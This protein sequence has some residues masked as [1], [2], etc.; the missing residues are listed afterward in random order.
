MPK[1][2]LTAVTPHG[3]FTRQTA[4]QYTH[5]V[6]REC[7]EARGA[8][9]RLANRIQQAQAEGWSPIAIAKNLACGVD[10][11]WAKDNGYAVTWHGS[12]GAARKAA[13]GKYLYDWSARVLG[14]YEVR[15]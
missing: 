10:A 2:I 3:T 4:T 1:P 6:V 15:S 12:E 9:E 8:A 13:D 7:E 14:I 11:R 5:V